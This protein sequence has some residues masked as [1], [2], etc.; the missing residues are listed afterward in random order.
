MVRTMRNLNSGVFEHLETTSPMDVNQGINFKRRL[1]RGAAIKIYM[2]VL[3]EY[4]ELAKE[5]LGDQWNRVDVK[6]LSMERF[7]TS[8]KEDG[9][10]DDGDAYLGIYKFINFEDEL[11][12][13][14]AKCMWRK[15]RSVLQDHVKYIHNDIVKPF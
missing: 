12:F 7:W 9:L 6:K 10:D 11:W 8:A 13:E 2:A 4:K 3:K 1:L 14:L 15:H 5:L